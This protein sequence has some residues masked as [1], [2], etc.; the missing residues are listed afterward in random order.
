MILT[1]LLDTYGLEKNTLVGFVWQSFKI[2][3]IVHKNNLSF[4]LVRSNV[5]MKKLVQ[6]TWL[7]FSFYPFVPSKKKAKMEETSSSPIILFFSH[8]NRSDDTISLC[9]LPS[10]A[11]RGREL[12]TNGID[13]LGWGVVAEVEDGRMWGYTIGREEG[14]TK[15][16]RILPGEVA[17]LLRWQ[18]CEKRM[19]FSIS[20]KRERYPPSL[21]SNPRKM[22]S[23]VTFVCRA[24]CVVMGGEDL[25]QCILTMSASFSSNIQPP[26]WSRLHLQIFI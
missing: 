15:W 1:I 8:K 9:S 13:G 4:T 26:T 3:S 11:Y 16:L 22:S 24:F 19:E 25:W 10:G 12:V 17:R 18:L 2:S 7:C 20:I 21:A 14:M 23:W 6:K 5:T